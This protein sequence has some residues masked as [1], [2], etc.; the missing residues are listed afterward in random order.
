MHSHVPDPGN[1][2]NVLRIDAEIARDEYQSRRAKFLG[3][4]GGTVTPPCAF[5]VYVDSVRPLRFPGQAVLHFLRF[6]GGRAHWNGHSTSNL[7]G[8]GASRHG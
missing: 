7:R 8:C 3:L 4:C 2:E 6:E 5:F 1:V